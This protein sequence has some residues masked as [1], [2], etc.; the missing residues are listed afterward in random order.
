MTDAGIRGIPG[1]YKNVDDI[2]TTSQSMEDLETRLRKLLL[3]CRL[4]NIKLNPS[5]FSIGHEVT[6]GGVQLQGV[7]EKGDTTRRVYITPAERRL[8]EF[9][10]IKT[11][12]TKKEVQRVIGLA[13][14]LKRWVPELAF[15]TLHL[16]K[17]SS[18]HARFLWS[19]EHDEELTQ[20]KAAIQNCV[21]LSPLD[22]KKPIH[23]HLDA[24][25]CTGMS[26]IL[27]Q[28]R[29]ENEADGKTIITC[30]STTFSETQTRYSP[31][32]CEAIAVQWATKSE[33]Y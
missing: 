11:P 32:E 27:C 13:N 7:K 4:R 10:A 5:K 31:F 26:Y 15:S 2:L 18:V 33:D 8:E 9:L 19:S 25:K 16:W 22:M 1:Y 30:N 17:L 12:T 6:F 28:P 29:S 3:I 21:K 24:A 23:L 20:L 14:Q